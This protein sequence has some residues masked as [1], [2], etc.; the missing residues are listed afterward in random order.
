VE[1][2][3]EGFELRGGFR[4]VW[5]A[6]TRASVSHPQQKCYIAFIDGQPAGGATLVFS[7]DRQ[8]CGLY[9]TS[10]MPEFRH[11]GVQSALLLTMLIE[12]LNS[13]VSVITAQAPYDTSAQRNLE[14]LNFKVG[15]IRDIYLN[16]GSV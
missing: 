2:V 9:S 11:H 8:Y 7:K 10:T 1:V 14:R 6:I 3:C 16:I 5:E 4:R 12:A 15:Y 13:R